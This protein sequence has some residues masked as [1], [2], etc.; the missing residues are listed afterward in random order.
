MHKHNYKRIRLF[1]LSFLFF[2]FLFNTVVSAQDGEAL[3][4]ANCTS[5]H[6]VKDKV[7]GPALQGVE[8]RHTEEWLLKWVKN[9]QTLVK[10]GDAEAVKLF[11]FASC[12]KA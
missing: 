2:S 4:K 10:A 8:G 1:F 7:V 11:D 6:A 5:C 9:S 3:F 12:R